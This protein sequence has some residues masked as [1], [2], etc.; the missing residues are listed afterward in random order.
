MKKS[1]TR[2]FLL[3][4]RCICFTKFLLVWIFLIFQ[5]GAFA[6]QKS[7]IYT[8]TEKDTISKFYFV[9]CCNSL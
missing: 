5:P 9:C 7:L 2:S 6:R 3:Q 4:D 8:I 1:A